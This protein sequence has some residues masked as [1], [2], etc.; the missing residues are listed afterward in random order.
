MT[1]RPSVTGLCGLVRGELL[2]ERGN[3]RLG[4]D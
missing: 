3:D 2:C 4:V 1:F